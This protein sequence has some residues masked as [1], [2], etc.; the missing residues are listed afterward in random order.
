[1][2]R[3][4]ARLIKDLTTA[5]NAGHPWVFD[6]ALAPL[7]DIA[8]GTVVDL[9]HQG[10][11]IAT[12]YADPGSPIAVRIL[13]TTA[14]A[15][16]DGDWAR[17]AAR[18][19]AAMRAVDPSLAGCDGVR[20]VHGESDGMP[21]LVIDSYA[22]W[23][24]VVF[25]GAGAAGFWRPRLDAVIEGLGAGGHAL[26]GAWVRKQ[27]RRGGGGELVAGVAPPELIEIVEHGALFEVDLRHGQKTGFFLDQRDNRAVCREL[28]AGARVL[29]LFGYTGGFSV[30]AALGGAV[31]VTTVDIAEPAIDAARRNF[32]RNDLAVAEHRFA[33]E[34]AFAFVA[35]ARQRGEEFEVVVCDPPS[36][37]PSARARGQA[38]GAY[39]KL[40]RAALEV[41]AS[42]GHIITASCS[43]HVGEA[44]LIECLARAASEVG[45]NVRLRQIRG[46]AT[47]H[48][49]RPSFPEG[50]YLCALV[51]FVD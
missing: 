4:V 12:G 13:S 11:D 34:D 18:R 22:G 45:R 40:N 26:L 28:A 51:G 2:H 30:H 16:V 19:A 49:V 21:G 50:R 44:D 5:I 15:A 10:A 9:R 36:F 1:M 35:G 33:A 32:A 24:A 29:N 8:P 27:G 6:R 14:G 39:R 23:A 38:L 48:P 37:A 43:S 31:A 7:G 17:D 25:D 42:G 20:L 47:D 41:V 46:A 3:K